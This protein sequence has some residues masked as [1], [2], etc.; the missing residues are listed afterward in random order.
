M[1]TYSFENFN[2]T[3]GYIYLPKN[4]IFYRGVDKNVS[5]LIRDIPIYLGPK[6][7]AK[8][9][10]G[11]VKENIKTI[12]TFSSIRLFDLR[13][14][15]NILPMIMDNSKNKKMCEMLMIAF[16]LCSYKDQI[17]LFG[18]FCVQMMQNEKIDK[19]IIP[20]LKKKLHYMDTFNWSTVKNGV[21]HNPIIPR[22]IR[23]GEPNIDNKVMLILKELFKDVCDGYIAPKLFSPY[24]I[25]NIAHEEI[26]IFNPKKELYEVLD[27]ADDIEITNINERINQNHIPLII[28]NLNLWMSKV[29]TGGTY[30]YVDKNSF[31]DNLSEKD[32][33]KYSAQAKKFVKNLNIKL[34]SSIDDIKARISYFKSEPD[35]YKLY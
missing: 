30:K 33:K 27:V 24:H 11:G 21:A 32:Y 6:Y 35:S 5:E 3:D 22:G 4:T 26:V 34:S 8:L 25:N 12:A 18:N 17:D 10:S 31:F 19:K 2:Y 1:N 7:I 9:Y 15:M 23:I 13:K 29:K 14:I 20:E 16:G 28:D